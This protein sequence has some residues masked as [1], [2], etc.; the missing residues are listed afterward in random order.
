MKHDFD[1]VLEKVRH[2]YDIYE[3]IRGTNKE[4]IKRK[5]KCRELM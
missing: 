4:G 2:S 3:K 5:T 1:N